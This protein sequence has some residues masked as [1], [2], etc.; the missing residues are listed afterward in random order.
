MRQGWVGGCHPGPHVPQVTHQWSAVPSNYRHR[1]LGSWRVWFPNLRLDSSFSFFF[2]FF[3]GLTG[4]GKSPWGRLIPPEINTA[5]QEPWLTDFFFPLSKFHQRKCSRS[6]WAELEVETRF[7]EVKQNVQKVSLITKKYWK[8]K[9]LLVTKE[10]GS[11]H[12]N[13]PGT[14]LRPLLLPLNTLSTETD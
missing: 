3:S 4:C 11:I 12:R 7:T 2:S 9:A 6:V 1:A 5:L 13:Q 8:I 14:I 10:V